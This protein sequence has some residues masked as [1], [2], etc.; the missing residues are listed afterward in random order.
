MDFVVPL[1][2]IRDNGKLFEFESTFL[3]E[4][5]WKLSEKDATLKPGYNPLQRPTGKAGSIDIEGGKIVA[6][7]S[8][9]EA[10]NDFV[11]TLHQQVLDLG[12]ADDW[13]KEALAA[14]LDRHIPHQDIPEGQSAS[15][16]L[17][18]INGLMAKH[19]ITDVST[20]A[21]DRFRLRDAIEERINEHREHERKNAFQAFLLPAS[22]LTVSPD[23]ALNFKTMSYEPSWLY[24][25]GF[26]FK[27]HYFGKPGELTEKTPG[28]QQTEE[29]NCAQFI[30]NLAEVK[31]WIRNLSKKPSSFR[32]QTSKDRFYP[33]FICQLTDGRV[34]VV[35]YKGQHLFTDAEEKRAVGEVW[36]S[37]SGGKCRFVMPTQGDFTSIVRAI[38]T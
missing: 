16:L 20:L 17:K 22:E 36:A 37:R 8:T 14:W 1:L 15:F 7:V 38:L 13:T 34:L 29:F 2:S 30:D 35:E 9:D 31:Y 24:E 26:Q 21:L 11:A 4:H 25:G 28:G 6:A 23:R 18:V 12:T 27:K 33:D 19:G 10:A 3:L 32:L 5:E